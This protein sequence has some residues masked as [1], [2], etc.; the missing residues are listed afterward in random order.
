MTKESANVGDNHKPRDVNGVAGERL[1]AFLERIERLAEE[2]KA[3]NEDIKEVF[4]E[5]K[6]VGFDAKIMRQILRMRAMDDEDRQEQEAL[7]DTYK[8][9]IGLV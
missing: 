9:A 2:R 7:L 4:E 5:A 1:K 3:I 6:G 8:L